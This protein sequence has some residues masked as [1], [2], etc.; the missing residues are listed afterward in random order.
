[1]VSVTKEAAR[2][3]V[4]RA[5]RALRR[6]RRTFQDA[7]DAVWFAEKNWAL[8]HRGYRHHKRCASEVRHAD[9]NLA[10]A[11]RKLRQAKNRLTDAE[12]NLMKFKQALRNS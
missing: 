8:S 2:R 9:A 6:A 12:D 5:E 11:Y 1:M 4:R 3:Q 7:E 10:R